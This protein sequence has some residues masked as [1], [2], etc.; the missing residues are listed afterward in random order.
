ME[1]GGRELAL[2]T[3]GAALRRLE[4]A[5]DRPAVAPRGRRGA[6]LPLG[7][8]GGEVQEPLGRKRGRAHRPHLLRPGGCLDPPAG[9][10][11]GLPRD[12]RHRRPSTQG[13]DPRHGA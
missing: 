1:R 13:R 7:W 10:A 8:P 5:R 9:D 2:G 11:T 12:R 3:D 4:A 6:P